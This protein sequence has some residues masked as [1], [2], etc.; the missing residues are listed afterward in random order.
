[1]LLLWVKNMRFLYIS[2]LRLFFFMHLLQWI[3]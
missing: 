2:I 1:M 3:L